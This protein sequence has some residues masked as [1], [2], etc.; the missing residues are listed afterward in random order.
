MVHK[1]ALLGVKKGQILA[2]KKE[3]LSSTEIAR[4]ND[5]SSFVV[6]NFLKLGNTYGIKMSSGC[7][8][9]LTPRQERKLIRQLGA[10]RTSLVKI[11]SRSTPSSTQIYAISNGSKKQ[12]ILVQQ[13]ETTALAYYRA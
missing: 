6:N 2:Y 10:L 11:G 3:G 12:S 13:K 9:K 5:R 1:L 8:R 4:R 7:P